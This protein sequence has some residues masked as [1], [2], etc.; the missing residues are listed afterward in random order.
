MNEKKY[1]IVIPSK[2]RH[3]LIKIIDEYYQCIGIDMEVIVLD[4]SPV[5]INNYSFKSIRYYWKPDF[6]WTQR[7]LF[8]L[9]NTS[10]DVIS[11]GADD[12]FF[13]PVGWERCA[14]F[15]NDNPEYT[16]CRG[17]HIRLEIGAEKYQFVEKHIAIPSEAGLEAD[18]AYE[19]VKASFEPYRQLIFTV[20]KKEYVKY[21]LEC[22]SISDECREF[23]MFEEV[24]TLYL[25]LKGKIKRIDDVFHVITRTS[26]N[27]T[28]VQTPH[29]L[30]EMYHHF[31]EI[32][33]DIFKR[34]EGCGDEYNALL[35]GIVNKQVMYQ[36]K[37]LCDKDEEKTKSGKIYK[38]ILSIYR[39]IYSLL[40]GGKLSLSADET[41]QVNSVIK[42]LNAKDFY[43]VIKNINN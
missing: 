32:G 5:A 39:R 15:L 24:M 20:A 26:L 41:D 34:E 18:S 33:E 29:C 38:R 1:A 11:I 9:K 27:D 43:N 3:A 14:K 8:G 36:F 35:N 21:L 13:I 42:Y 4:A 10:A 40:P 16:C 28:R 22:Y 7:I 25:A 30:T 12:D 17:R 37:V 6:S 2:G 31:Y 23:E 19:R